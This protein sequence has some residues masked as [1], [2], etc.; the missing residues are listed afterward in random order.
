MSGNVAN[1]VEKEAA[2]TNARA[3]LKNIPRLQQGLS[4]TITTVALHCFAKRLIPRTVYEGM[5]SGQWRPEYARAQYFVD[6]VLKRL[7]QYEKSD[8]GAVQKTI[9]TLASIVRRDGALEH[10]ATRIGKRIIAA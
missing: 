8:P 6:C 9:T 3:F 1:K 2:N 4:S 7:E 5:F 10:I